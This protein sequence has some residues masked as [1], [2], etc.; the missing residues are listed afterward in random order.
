MSTRAQLRAAMLAAAAV[1]AMAAGVGTA[2]ANN[3]NDPRGPIAGVSV[4]RVVLRDANGA[5]IG[6]VANATLP[7]GSQVTAQSRGASAAG[8]SGHTPTTVATAR[9]GGG[10]TFATIQGTTGLAPATAY[11]GNGPLRIGRLAMPAGATVNWTVSGSHGASFTL[12]GTADHGPALA[13]SSRA[14]R[15]SMRVAAGSYRNV[16]V[17]AARQWTLVLAPRH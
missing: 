10:V 15:G 7:D 5:A 9:R 2:I 16:V 13:V 14:A 8:A 11:R 12:R 6:V 17:D 4:Q 1:A 3:A